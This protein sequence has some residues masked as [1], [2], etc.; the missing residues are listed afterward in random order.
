MQN[1]GSQE[2]IHSIRISDPSVL[3]SFSSKA[4]VLHDS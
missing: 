3:S 2:F 4:Q 1:D